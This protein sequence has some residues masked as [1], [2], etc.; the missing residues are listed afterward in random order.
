MNQLPMFPPTSDWQPPTELPDLGG[1]TIAIDLETRDDALAAGRGTGWVYSAGHIVGVGVAWDGGELYAPTRHDGENLPEDQVREWVAHL[2]KQCTVVFQNAQYDIGWLWA[3]W[4]IPTPTSIHDTILAAV[5]L[6]ENRLSYNLNSICSWLGI[7][8]KNEAVLQ[9]AARAWGIDPKKELW[10]LPAN[11]VGAYGQQDARATLDAFRVMVPRLVEQ[12]LIPAYNLDRDLLPMV[13]EMRKRGIRVDLDRAERVARDF[14]AARDQIIS[15]LSG[16]LRIGRKLT[17]HDINSPLFLEKVFTSEG[18]QFPRTPKTGHGSFSTD[19]MMDHTHWLPSGVARATDYHDMA[20][21]FVRGFVIG[22]A[23]RGRLH[24]EVH[25]H[26]SDEGG[27]RSHRF[28]YSDPPLQQMPSPSR[29]DAGLL[30]RTCFLPE[31]GELWLG[32]DYSQQEYRLIVH[33]GVV[34][35][36]P[37][38]EDAA[39]LYRRDPH[40]DFHRLVVDWTGLDRPRAKDT[41]FAKAFG[42]GVPKFASMIGKTQEEAKRIYELYDEKLPFV[43]GA[44]QK[45]KSVADSRGYVKLIDGARC[46]FDLWEVAWREEGE[47]WT[48]AM[49]LEA[50][51]RAHPDRR[52]R[53][54]FTHK[55]FNRLIQG[56]AARQMKLAM[57]GCWQ[58][59]IVPLLQMHDELGISTTSEG[60]VG[61]VTEIMRDVVKLEVPVVVDCEVGLSWGTVKKRRSGTVGRWTRRK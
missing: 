25:S 3:N 4:G 35:H 13:I 28:S 10:R 8:G 6:D 34:T 5:M 17:I 30:I 47:R 19:W 48:P 58:A 60:T 23:H 15:E 20:S 1:Q 57:R 52:L 55:A 40:T 18:V 12:D 59:G 39:E 37:R 11:Q 31:E 26:R 38:A 45:A 44:S 2:C 50:A 53:R 33:Y 24:A 49:P 36:Q 27:T 42:A 46:R 29:S 22:Y 61:R 16:H 54:A 7:P 41:N 14:E 43:S 56:S 32:P 21:K 9:E 51:R